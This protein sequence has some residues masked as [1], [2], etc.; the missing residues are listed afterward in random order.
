MSESLKFLSSLQQELKFAAENRPLAPAKNWPK[1]SS[2]I[3]LSSHFA[4]SSTKTSFCSTEK[5]ETF[6]VKLEAT[7]F[8]DDDE[9][10]FLTPN[11][12]VEPSVVAQVEPLLD[13]K[14]EQDQS[15]SLRLAQLQS[16]SSKTETRQSS[17]SKVETS[18]LKLK[19]TCVMSTQMVG[20][21]ST[22]IYSI[23]I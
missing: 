8:D 16:S 4:K 6:Q 20:S 10:Q 3:D 2:T 19:S 5:F 1:K 7:P 13:V 18:D 21:L 9:V 14:L 11:V 22:K 15:P 23:C 12:K 17:N